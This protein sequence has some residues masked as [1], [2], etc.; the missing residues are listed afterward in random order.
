MYNLSS[1]ENKFQESYKTFEKL[2]DQHLD[3]N[4]SATRQAE[5]ILQNIMVDHGLYVRI[6]DCSFD[7][8]IRISSSPAKN[9][10]EVFFTLVYHFTPEAV[11]LSNKNKTGIQ[12]SKLWNTVFFTSK[13]ALN[14]DILPG[15]TVKCFS[16]SF[17]GEWIRARGLF[18]SKRQMEFISEIITAV[19]PV[20]FFESATAFEEKMIHDIYNHSSY[21]QLGIL[22]IKARVFAI[23]DHFISK[24]SE[25]QSLLA[26][27]NVSAHEYSIRQ[28]EARLIQCLDSELLN[29][30][31]LAR[32][33]A[34]SVSTLNRSFKRM[35]G[36]SINDYYLDKKMAYAK[37]LIHERNKTVTET[38][39]LLGYGKVSHFIVMFKK[40]IGCLPG[41]IR[42]EAMQCK[43]TI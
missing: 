31:D 43:I 16:I 38:A 19:Q 39:Y 20:L 34:L 17:T 5:G 29:I 24:A 13:A 40:Y 36:K 14:T 27:A 21:S 11:V 12:L 33:F 35:Y 1:H 25:R 10:E 3:F 37:Q 18:H 41:T 42:K 22:F 6:W 30:K 26:P 9:S 32:E 8:T 4:I 7:K 28:V 23:I 2:P 15:R